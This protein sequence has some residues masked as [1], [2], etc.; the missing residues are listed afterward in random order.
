MPSSTTEP[1]LPDCSAPAPAVPVRPALT[2]EQK[3]R[4]GNAILDLINRDFHEDFAD[5]FATTV[6][7]IER[8]PQQANH[9]IRNALNHMARAHDAPSLD[10]ALQEIR[11]ARGHIERGKR[12]CLKLSII[13]K[14]RQL[15]TML[16]RI[17]AKYGYVDGEFRALFRAV[18]VKR[19]DALKAENRGAERVSPALEDILVDCLTLEKKLTERHVVPSAAATALRRFGWRL[20]RY[21]GSLAL[22]TAAGVVSAFV[23]AL[24]FPDN[25][26]VKAAAGA[27]WAAVVRWAG[28]R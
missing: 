3:A 1:P 5:V 11:L 19:R 13:H 10:E 20:R 21:A 23:F 28:F 7:I 9:E 16:E 17:E 14:R 22:G 27:V 18:E 24:V 8:I 12:D 25:A 4:V 6:S 26:A 2:D 15:A